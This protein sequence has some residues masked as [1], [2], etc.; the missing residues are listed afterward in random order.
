MIVSGILLF[1]EF[2]LIA[3]LFKTQL[4]QTVS[5]QY[6]ISWFVLANSETLLIA[7]LLILFAYFLLKNK[8][9]A[10]FAA[11]VL[12]LK[13]VVAGINSI[14]LLFSFSDQ[15]SFLKELQVTTSV[16]IFTFSIVATIISI[17]IYVSVLISLIFLIKYR[18]DYWQIVS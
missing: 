3:L 9:W 4:N 11:M 10:W 12:L 18:K 7:G 8:K 15:I 17:L 14:P 1:C 5:S 16:P 13:E 6:N 2:I